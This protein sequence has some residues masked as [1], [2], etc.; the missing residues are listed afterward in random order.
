V[1]LSGGVGGA[2]LA[3]GIS[4]IIE[5]DSLA[6]IV[7][8]G[9]D[10]QHLGLNI[11]PDLD[12]V[13][14]TLA[15]C[16]NRDT[17]WGRRN[18][19]WQCMTTLAELG[20]ET[21]FKLGDRD[22]ATHFFR[23]ERMQNGWRLTEVMA[24]LC[25]ALSVHARL[26]PA[27]DDTLAT[28]VQTTEGPLAFQDYFVRRAAE[29]VVQGI[30][31]RGAERARAT[32]EVLDAL[33]A[34]HLEAVLIAPSNPYLSIDPLLAIP[35]FDRALRD[36]PAPVLA[37]SPIVGGRAL[38]GPTAKIMDELG[39]AATAA[40]VARHYQP[41]IDGFVMDQ[42]DAQHRDEIEAMGIPVHACDT[43][44]RSLDDRIALGQASLDFAR[45]CRDEKRERS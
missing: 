10:F 14:Y 2:K 13:L 19:S 11:C 34:E 28:C 40:S 20:G 44:M 32:P 23:T 12:T 1:V 30:E 17:G 16:V 3:L 29:P 6:V 33:T 24:E 43:I 35:D 4:R 18:E 25:A 5:D 27:T 42:V 39:L 36:T 7:N 15:D 37:V 41:W 45:R 38:K 22:L 31:F 21:W 26:L 9:D 8:T